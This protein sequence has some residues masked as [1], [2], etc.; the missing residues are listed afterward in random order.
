M[1][2][3]TITLTRAELDELREV[4]FDATRFL[5]DEEPEDMRRERASKWDNILDR[6]AEGN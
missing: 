5:Q 4:V 2:D 3:I 1:D 6:I